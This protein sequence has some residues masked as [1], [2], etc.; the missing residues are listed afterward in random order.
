MKEE[1]NF[2]KKMDKMGKN[3]E[4]KGEEFGKKVEKNI[5]KSRIPRI[6]G[7][8]VAIAINIVVLW[9]LSKLPD[10]DFKFLTEKYVDVLSIV[11]LSLY[12]GIGGNIL[13]I[14]CD[15]QWFKGIIQI[16]INIVSFIAALA[17]YRVFPFDF[18]AVNQNWLTIFIK[19][20][21]IVVM[22]GIAIGAIVEFVKLFTAKKNKEKVRC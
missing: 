8:V 1:K 13:L 16:I 22:V 9:I 19:V 21:L 20:F 5:E 14:V 4:K 17:I 15:T 6:I 7:Y 11:E 3:W 12:V 10:W 18:G 2:E